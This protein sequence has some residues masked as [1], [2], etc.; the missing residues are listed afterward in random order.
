MESTFFWVYLI[1]I[2]GFCVAM[3]VLNASVAHLQDRDGEVRKELSRLDRELRTLTGAKR[4]E[5]SEAKR[6]GRPRKITS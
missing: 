1:T 4:L 3:F 6:L 5:K 2:F